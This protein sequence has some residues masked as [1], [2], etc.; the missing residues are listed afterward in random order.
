MKEIYMFLAWLPGAMVARL[1]S[2]AQRYQKVAGSSPA[3]VIVFAAECIGSGTSVAIT[4]TAS[5]WPFG[6][7]LRC[8][9]LDSNN[10]C[11]I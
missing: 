4:C 8:S 1:A 3:V 6:A 10:T 2:I 9:A 7:W 5:A 11:T